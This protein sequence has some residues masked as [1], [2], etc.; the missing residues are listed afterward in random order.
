MVSTTETSYQLLQSL[1]HDI[2]Q[3]LST[4]ENS[5]YYLNLL[6]GAENPQIQEQILCIQAQVERAAHLLSQLAAELK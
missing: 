6:T 4:I 1:V 5:A 2:R 3:P